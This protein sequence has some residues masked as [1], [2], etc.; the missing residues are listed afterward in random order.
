MSILSKVCLFSGEV[1][2]D[3]SPTRSRR[4]HIAN[5]G[6]ESRVPQRRL[7]SL[8]TKEISK[9]APSHIAD[10]KVSTLNESLCSRI[11]ITVRTR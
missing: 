8:A 3:P 4:Q 11:S 7:F 6:N 2:S 5:Q 1:V 9:M 10:Q